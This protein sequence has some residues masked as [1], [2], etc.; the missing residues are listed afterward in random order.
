MLH[1]QAGFI[2]V[3]EIIHLYMQLGDSHDLDILF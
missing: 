3:D 2:S 1:S